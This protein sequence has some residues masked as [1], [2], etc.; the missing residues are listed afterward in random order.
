M[1]NFKQLLKE[2]KEHAEGVTKRSEKYMFLSRFA[3]M[4]MEVQRTIRTIKEAQKL[5][6]MVESVEV[7]V[8]S[9][10]F[11]KIEAVRRTI[12]E[13]LQVLREAI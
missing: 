3:E 11:G 10:S 13:Q 5:L 9:L 6:G 4:D 8:D 12:M 1:E 7:V 2:I